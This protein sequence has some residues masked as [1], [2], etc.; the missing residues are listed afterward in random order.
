[1]RIQPSLVLILSIL[2][3]GSC[4][5]DSKM[6]PSDMGNT[7]NS[8]AEYEWMRQHDPLNGRIP[9]NIRAL[10]L[11]FAS[12]LPKADE[13]SNPLIW[14]ER[15]PWN[16]GGR[17]RGFA[18]DVTNENH[19]IAGS[20]SGSVWDS[21]DGGQTWSRAVPQDQYFGVTKIV[22]DT[23]PGHTN[24]W[25]YSTGEPYGNSATGSSATS[26]YLGNGIYKSMD[27]GHTW[28]LLPATTNGSPQSYNRWD[29]IWNIALDPSDT[30]EVIFAACPGRL[31]SSFDG[32]A[33]WN[34]ALGTSIT[35]SSYFT[36]VAVTPGGVVYATFSSESGDKGVFRSDDGINFN[37]IDP[38]G[39]PG[40]YNRVVIGIS[41]VDEDVVYFLGNTPGYGK[42]S[43]LWRGD[44]E[45]NSL[46]RYRYV[47]GNGSGAGGV[48]EDLSLNL[49]G[50]EPANSFNAQ[51]SYNLLVRVKPGDSTTVFIGGTNLYRST[52]AF[53]SDSNITHIG[54]YMPNT[55]VPFYQLY[56]NQHPDH[57][58]LFFSP[59][60]PDVMFNGN[61][62]GIFKTL[63]NTDSTVVWTS[64]NNGYQTTQYYTVGI[65]HA[66][67]GSD[68]IVGGLQDN[69]TLFQNSG[70]PHQPWVEV[71]QGDGSY[72]AVADSSKMYYFSRQKGRMIKETLDG[73]GQVQAFR[74][75]DPAGGYRYLFINPFIID[76][77]NNDLM[78]LAEGYNLWRN[79]DLSVIP[80]DGGYD[81]I[82]T[83]WMKIVDSLNIPNIWIT[84]LAASVNPPN[85]LFYGTSSKRVY[86]IEN[87]DTGYHQPY[88]INNN[89]P[90]MVQGAFVNCIAVDP[91]DADKVMLVVSNY[92]VYSLFYTEN[93]GL[94]WM[95]V[96][97]NLEQTSSGSGN[98]PS[99]RWA[100]IMP[101]GNKT[102]YWLATSVG[103]FATDSLD[104]LNT[105]WIQQAPQS[106]GNNVVDMVVTRASDGRVVVATHGNGIWA[107]TITDPGQISGY[108]EPE[109]NQFRITAYPNPSVGIVNVEISQLQPGQIVDVRVFDMQG[110]IVKR[111]YRGPASESWMKWR[112][113]SSSE[114]AGRLPEGVYIVNVMTSNSSRSVRICVLAP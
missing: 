112:W 73:N 7:A 80:L 53:N 106:I 34:T 48:W 71:S 9:S 42:K 44:E 6:S 78:Y 20:V 69:G 66:M 41:P 1:M 31:Y 57:H 81:S 105:V 8:R 84:A 47:S 14:E 58:E 108:K 110:R 65:D 59:S 29:L 5:S 38:T 2:F 82:S 33:T 40:A 35:S 91:R 10:E 46:W 101:V 104:D 25:Y 103:L 70:N 11:A 60:N 92:N 12:T 85:I 51:G 15:G 19:L 76:P 45:W 98:G 68:V 37:R 23:R 83:N 113:D 109:K 99:I 49:P 102:V 63:N 93:G 94:S 30:G 16:V 61:D 114:T 3:L 67:A 4:T 17:T 74:R 13:R 21:W 88:L 54:G 55:T 43:I 87:A 26:Y 89:L 24:T 107:T 32:G 77:N 50:G 96:A 36:D 100:S 95:R 28:S 79:S 62:G 56:P 52:D 90:T 18:M 22:Q 39:W 97:G 111:L 72:L 64:L 27:N 86:R 75:I